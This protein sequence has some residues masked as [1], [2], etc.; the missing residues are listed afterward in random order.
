MNAYDKFLV[1]LD[2]CPPEETVI[3]WISGDLCSGDNN[4]SG[5][6]YNRTRSR[7]KEESEIEEEGDQLGGLA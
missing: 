5:Q 2:N 4:R 6:I 7:E 3:I 1:S